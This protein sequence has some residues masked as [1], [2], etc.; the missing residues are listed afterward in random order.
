MSKLSLA[1]LPLMTSLSL[2]GC[3][4]LHRPDM[5][6]YRPYIRPPGISKTLPQGGLR[7]T[8]YGTTSLLFDDGETQLMTDGFI[9][10]PTDWNQL[11]FG[12]VSS[13]RPLIW[14]VLQRTGVQQLSALMIFHSH[15]DHAMDIGPVAWLTGAQVMG[16]E[17]TANIA[18]GEG[19]PADRII[20][21]KPHHPYTFGKF[22]VTFIPSQHTPLPGWIEATGMMGDITAPLSQPASIFDYR[23]GATYTIHIAHPQGTAILKGGA[24]VPGE[25]K[26]YKADTIFMCTPGLDKMPPEKQQQYFKEVVLDTGA[27]RVIPVHWDDF[28]TPLAA[29]MP[30]MPKAAENLDAS[31]DF[32]L[33]TLKAHPHVRFEFVPALESLPLINP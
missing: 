20:V 11:F 22:K 7:F 19:L 1:L 12:Q 9:T 24:F 29:V 25:L 4:A 17:S 16:S 6:V 31:M 30:P 8:Y 27:T 26:G 5:E 15:F 28:S 14:D 2:Q 21:V 10:R 32:L 3:F 23:E 18:R 13:D 33:P